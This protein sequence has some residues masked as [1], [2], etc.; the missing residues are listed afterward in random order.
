M[1]INVEPN[2]IIF[3]NSNFVDQI[4]KKIQKLKTFC[5]SIISVDVYLKEENAGNNKVITVK[6]QMPRKREIF[7]SH[8]SR[9]FEQSLAHVFTAAVAQIKK[10][11]KP[12]PV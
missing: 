9:V 12:L 1:D 10:A 3:E 7:V 6:V 11:K 2:G 5:S 4:E 8:T